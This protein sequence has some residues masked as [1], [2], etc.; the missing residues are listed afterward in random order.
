MFSLKSLMPYSLNFSAVL[1]H[2][3]VLKESQAMGKAAEG[4]SHTARQQEL[5]KRYQINFKLQISEHKSYYYGSIIILPFLSLSYLSLLKIIRSQRRRPGKLLVNPALPFRADPRRGPRG[6][7]C[8]KLPWVN[9]CLCSRGG[10]GFFVC[11]EMWVSCHST[12]LVLTYFVKCDWHL[13]DHF[14]VQPCSH[15]MPMQVKRHRGFDQAPK[16]TCAMGHYSTFSLE[17]V[18]SSVVGKN[19]RNESTANHPCIFP[20]TWII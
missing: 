10:S 4:I 3:S 11:F 2:N 13:S 19:C 7:L 12:S 8:S 18:M 1:V 14:E 20:T 16:R 15:F 5:W 9:F 6:L 17:S